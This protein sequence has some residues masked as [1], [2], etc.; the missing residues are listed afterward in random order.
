[1]ESAAIQPIFERD[2]YIA[3]PVFFSPPRVAMIR[4]HVEQ[5]L[6]SQLA[7]LP[8]ECRFLSDS[9]R[10]ESVTHVQDIHRY[11]EFFNGLLGD[12]TLRR[13]AETVLRGPVAGANVHYY[14]KPPG[15]NSKTP[16][17]QDGVYARLAPK[18]TV[19]LWLALD[20]ADENTGCLHYVRGS[21][22]MGLLPHSE[23]GIPS[24]H[25]G[26]SDTSPCDDPRT[27][28][29]CRVRAGDLLVH[30]ALTIHWAS[31]NTSGHKHRRALGFLYVSQRALDDAAQSETARRAQD[32]GLPPAPVDATP[33]AESNFGAT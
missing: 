20:D 3:L 27:L 1:M 17:H 21:H 24:F 7:A 12:V 16:P 18:D 28:V 8:P 9:A 19:E 6:A 14:D 30:N 15:A 23:T 31:E 2:G 10:P 25:L 29:P 26:L 33:P 5:F 4:E 32:G 11:D 22:V 13:V